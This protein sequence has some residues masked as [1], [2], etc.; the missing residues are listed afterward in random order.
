MG[1]K[2]SLII[3]CVDISVYSIKV[4]IVDMKMQAIVSLGVIFELQNTYFVL[5]F[6]IIIC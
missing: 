6:K 2:Y 1:T 5:L 3:V 4:F